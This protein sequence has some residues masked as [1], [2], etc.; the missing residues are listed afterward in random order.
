MSTSGTAIMRWQSSESRL[1]PAQAGTPM[2][3]YFFGMNFSAAE[4]MQ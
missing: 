4:F 2:R 1:Q 3:A